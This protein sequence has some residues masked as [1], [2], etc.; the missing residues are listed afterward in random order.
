MN[1]DAEVGNPGNPNTMHLEFSN[2]PNDEGDGETGKTPDK[3]VLVFTYELDTT[4]VDGQN[5]DTKLEGAE[6]RLFKGE[7]GQDGKVAEANRQYVKITD[8]KV[9]G[10]TEAG[11][12]EGAATLTSDKEGLF[13]ISG[14]DAGTYY[15]EETK[16]PTGYNLLAD[17]IKVVITAT[18]K[19]DDGVLGVENALEKLEITVGEKTEAGNASTGIVN[20]TVQNNKGA[21][22]PETGG[23]GTTIFYVVGGLLTVG[24]VV[25]LVTKKRMSAD[26]DK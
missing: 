16:A 8:G 5:P 24:A 26:S 17:P 11:V 7:A 18:I 3:E 14:L 13:V 25:L 19:D 1:K 21:T 22:L 10:W 4:K 2:N 15:L 20:T 6:F 23:I 9:S 12:T